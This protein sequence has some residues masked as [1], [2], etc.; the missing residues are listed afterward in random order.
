[1]PAG[2]PLAKRRNPHDPG[3]QIHTLRR[4]LPAIAARAPA[5][6]VDGAFPAEDVAALRDAGLLAAPLPEALGGA[7]LGTD[8]AALAEALRLVGRAS[9]PLGRLYEGHVNA[10]RLVLRHGDAEQ[11]DAAAADAR[12]GAFFGVWNTDV[13]GEILRLETRPGGIR[14]Q[15]R[16]IL[17]SGAGRVDRALV[18]ARARP[19]DL[20]QMVLVPLPPGESGGPRPLDGAGHAR[21]GDRRGRFHRP[22]PA[23]RGADRP[24]RRL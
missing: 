16:K 13:P 18:T 10:L 9:L 21:L 5:L 23:R 1:M 19:E 12:D 6:D 3:R 24:A 17:C 8:P 7:G 14:L 22:R 11:R 20:P 15:G 4:I 2:V